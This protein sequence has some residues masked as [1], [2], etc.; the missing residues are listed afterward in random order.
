[1]QAGLILSSLKELFSEFSQAPELSPRY[2][3]ASVSQPRKNPL[4]P[5]TMPPPLP[6]QHAAQTGG[7]DPH[8]PD[9]PGHA[10]CSVACLRS[11]I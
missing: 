1:M 4:P 9:L 5:H 3:V 2:A 8:H 6:P 11:G 7:T 10:L